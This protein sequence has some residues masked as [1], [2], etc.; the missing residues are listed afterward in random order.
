LEIGCGRTGYG[1]SEKDK[2]NAWKAGYAL[3]MMSE[4][5]L[6]V[7]TCGTTGGVALASGEEI[8]AEKGLPERTASASLLDA[9]AAMMREAG[10]AVNELNGVGVVSG[11]GSFT[12]VRVGL[13][14]AKGLCEALGVPMAAVSRLEVLQDVSG[15]RVAVMDAGRGEVFVRSLDGVERLVAL[16]EMGEASVAVDEERLAG[17]LVEVDVR[18]VTVGAKDAWAAVKRRM[19]SGGS[20]VALVDANYVRGEQQIYGKAKA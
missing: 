10:W 15:G 17:K 16:E 5:W 14:A 1:A 6:L 11:P 2:K 9:V 18:V 8:V 7:D 3:E 13:A 4:K 19:A 20:D 12:G